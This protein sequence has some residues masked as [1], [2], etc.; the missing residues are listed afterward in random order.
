MN[1]GYGFL[2]QEEFTR[3]LERFQTALETSKALSSYPFLQD[4]VHTA[5]GLAHLGLANYP[6]AVTAFSHDYYAHP[7]ARSM[8]YW[9]AGDLGNAKSAIWNA[10]SE[11]PDNP[12]YY[13]QL[14]TILAEE[15]HSEGAAYWYLQAYNKDPSRSWAIERWFDIEAESGK[16]Y[17]IL[18][19]YHSVPAGLKSNATIEFCLGLAALNLGDTRQAIGIFREVT[20][21]NEN[22]VAAYE[23]LAIC[24]RKI[25]DVQTANSYAKEYQRR[26]SD[27]GMN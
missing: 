25:G 26:L 18:E 1:E 10:I 12:I 27:L 20:A 14:A 3:A 22:Y 7:F 4:E 23:Q 15:G 16:W 21:V 6:Q 5:L 24:Y 19:E 8:T 9:L 13:Q 11:E 2:K 17:D